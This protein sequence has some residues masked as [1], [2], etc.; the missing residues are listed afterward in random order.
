VKRSEDAPAYVALEI[1]HNTQNAAV[2]DIYEAMKNIIFDS[3]LVFTKGILVLSNSYAIENFPADHGRY[4]T[5]WVGDLTEH[6]AKDIRAKRKKDDV[7]DYIEGLNATG[8]HVRQLEAALSEAALEAW[9]E[10]VV[11]EVRAAAEVQKTREIMQTLP[12]SPEG[13]AWHQLRL[14]NGSDE[15]IKQVRGD[16]WR[17]VV[18]SLGPRRFHWASPEHFRAWK[19]TVAHEAERYK[20]EL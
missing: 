17:V 19:E 7:E 12:Q 6:E 15:L 4:K 5:V 8:L 2:T 11:E 16:V 1:N 13:V 14:G 10:R 9:K 3:G 20:E 18:Y